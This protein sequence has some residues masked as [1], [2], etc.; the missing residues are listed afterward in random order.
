MKRGTDIVIHTGRR[1]HMSLSNQARGGAPFRTVLTPAL[2]VLFLCIFWV[3]PA[4]AQ[5]SA[6]ADTQA[7]AEASAQ[8]SAEA[9][10]Q[11]S[12]G[13]D[14]QQT[15]APAGLIPVGQTGAAA[16]E[17]AEPD[18]T[19]TP[20]QR[21]QAALQQFLAA[22]ALAKN[23]LGAVYYAQGEID[24]A[25]VHIE[26][27]LEVAP[28][29]AAAYL[30]L[31]LVHHARG[32][33]NAAL[34]AFKKTVEGD[35]LSIARMTIVPTDTVYAWARSQYDRMMEGPPELAAAHTAMAFVYNQGGYLDEAAHHYRQAIEDDSSYVDAYTNLGKVYTDTE[36]FE[37]AADTYE[38]VLTL[39]P[40][41]DQL[42]R[43][44]LNLGVSYLNMDR[45]D[46]AIVEWKRAVELAPD[47]MDAYMNLGTAYQNKDQP[48]STRA[49]WERA[50]EVGGQSVVP[51]VALARLAFAEGRFSDALEYYGEIL[52]MGARDPRIYAETA[53][54]HERR[55][56]FGQAIAQ[57]EQALA[58]APEN[59][60]LKAALSRVRRV[61]EERTK[62][63]ESNKIRV[64][65]IV[66]ATQ[67]E[68][69]AV[70]ERLEAG[71]DFVELARETSIDS[72]RNVGGDLG[73]FGPGEMIPE[74]ERAAMGLQVG[75]LSA[76]VETSMGFH[77]IKRI[78]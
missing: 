56:E 33:M 12:A 15:P 52:E 53:M 41:E 57:Y 63:I 5:T 24:S 62:A 78:E 58:L 73:F 67:A 14:V 36:E 75:E 74:F 18:T 72:S 26:H 10:T 25:Q 6:E 60:P 11:T 77:I 39:S 34:D 19:L 43:I 76:V 35:T 21:Q 23:N 13:P 50:L 37:K 4:S 44:H 55:E 38:K 40:P 65:Q 51:R 49:V 66:V 54:I 29:F 2:S 70:M 42:P 48:D 47:Y 9:G 28:G 64:R 16:G 68:A 71:A 3:A 30:T 22:V 31:G 59:A 7:S 20:E 27:A 69:Q 61:V 1:W 8:T 45:V 46:D 17:G 32:D